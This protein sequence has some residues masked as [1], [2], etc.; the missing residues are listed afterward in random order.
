MLSSRSSRDKL[1]T[2]EQSK[3]GDEESESIDNSTR[4]EKSKLSGRAR[5][6][7]VSPI[8]PLRKAK[9]LDKSDKEFR[10]SR[11]SISTT[12]TDS[13]LGE[14]PMPTMRRQLSV[15][16]PIL[17]G[18]LMDHSD[19]EAAKT[20]KPVRRQRSTGRIDV[21]SHS[22]HSRTGL[23]ESS[24]RI[25]RSS[26]RTAGNKNEL[27][28][29][30]SHHGPK[31]PRRSSGKKSLGAPAGESSHHGSKSPRRSSSKKKLGIDSGSRR[32]RKSRSPGKERPTLEDENKS[33]DALFEGDIPALAKI[34]I[35]GRSGGEKSML[36][37]GSGEQESFPAEKRPSQ[38]LNSSNSSLLDIMKYPD[39]P[40]STESGESFGM[41]SPWDCQ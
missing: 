39:S 21:S 23:D 1:S 24:K 22:R 40:D 6:R 9:S 32:Q 12:T 35:S 26:R 30:S 7:K 19:S 13:S 37:D 2:S 4:G 5:P 17:D 8:S 33:S 31:S 20:K 29:E 18:S 28:G 34:I 27:A 41:L 15:P 25:S 10:S 16:I 36:T 38:S 14:L 11:S 3:H